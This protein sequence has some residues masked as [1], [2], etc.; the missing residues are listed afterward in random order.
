MKHGTEDPRADQVGHVQMTFTH[1]QPTAWGGACAVV[2]RFMDRIRFREWVLGHVPV[3]AVDPGFETR[4][5]VM[6]GGLLRAQKGAG[7]GPAKAA[8]CGVQD[9]GSAGGVEEAEDDP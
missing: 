8:Q 6:L 1:K 7:D 3:E 9:S 5:E 4:D 2:T